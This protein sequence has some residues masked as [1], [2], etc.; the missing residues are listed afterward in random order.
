MCGIVGVWRSEPMEAQRAC[1]DIDMMR[2][3]VT[4]RGP[5]SHGT[6]LSKHLSVGFQHLKIMDKGNYA[7]QP[8]EVGD[9]RVWLNGCIYNFKDLRKY[10][11]DAGRCFNSISDTEV[12]ASFIDKKGIYKAV[13]MLNGMF[14]FV[15]EQLSTGNVYIVRDRYGIK[16]M[17]WSP[18]DDGFAFASE[19]KALLKHPEV[20]LI[21]N[22]R[23]IGQ[24]LSF[25]NMLT[26]DT[27]FN[28]IYPVPPATIWCLNTKNRT[29]YWEWDFTPKEIPYVDAVDE[30]AY[31]LERAVKSQ[32]CSDGEKVTSWLSGGVD[33][34]AISL[35]GSHEKMF[36]V[37]FEDQDYGE[38]KYAAIVAD[39]LGKAV[40]RDTYDCRIM[41]QTLYDTVKSLDT[42]RAGPSWSN[43]AAYNETRD[44][45]FR[46]CLQGTGADELFGGYS[47]RYEAKDY[48]NVVYRSKVNLCRFDFD[49]RSF[50]QCNPSVS[51]RYKWDAENFLAGVLHVGDHLSMAHGIE[52]RVPFLDNDLVNFAC[53]LPHEYKDNKKILRE[54]LRGKLPVGILSRKK[55]GFTSPEAVWYYQPHNIARIRKL[56]YETPE[57]HEY[58][59][60]EILGSLFASNNTPALWSIVALAVWCRIHLRGESRE[61]FNTFIQ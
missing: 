34:S 35:Y 3:G 45:G 10:L 38:G 13:P 33:S 57:L 28:G 1:S 2:S 58:V 14:S 24:W 12:L 27:M 32:M 20:R 37:D 56:V 50:V 51:E 26:E 52:D 9:W 4:H 5:D 30:C 23:S 48:F 16:P 25:Q 47:W 43:W 29:T 22:K 17:Y 54:A 59:Y 36:M 44:K 60:P 31:L 41:W 19:A 11:L 15:A 42:L 40:S 61:D 18:I 8:M 39:H 21:P 6:Y 53:S 7:S 49:C 46:V 55:K